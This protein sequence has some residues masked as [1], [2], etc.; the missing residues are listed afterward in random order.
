[1][2][3]VL[4]KGCAAFRRQMLILVVVACCAAT[5]CSST[6]HQPV[7]TEIRVGVSSSYA[8]WIDKLVAIFRAKLN[9]VTFSTREIAGSVTSADML[10]T[11][12]VDV[13]ITG[14]YIAYSAFTTGTET[15]PTPHRTMRGMAIATVS[16][17][18]LV[19]RP[20]ANIKTF[21]DLRGKRIGV[22]PLGSSTE[23]TVRMLLPEFGMSFSDVDAV[24]I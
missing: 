4:T 7:K 2:Y 16:A 23:F 15:M 17:L 18:H 10:E 5:G 1:M 11:G 22:G 14:A 19:A 9:N 13:T 12:Q 6:N 24:R 21:D 3:E 8:S 20:D